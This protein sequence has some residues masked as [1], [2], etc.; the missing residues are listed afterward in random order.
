MNKTPFDQLETLEA[1]R[2][3]D[4]FAEKHELPTDYVYMEFVD[5]EVASIDTVMKAL[6]V[7]TLFVYN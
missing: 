5:P 3:C 1:Y 7:D 2:M 4:A 6:D